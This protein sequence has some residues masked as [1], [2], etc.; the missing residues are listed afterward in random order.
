[1]RFW[2]L[3]RRLSQQARVRALFAAT[4]DLYYEFW[5]PYFHLAIFDDPAQGFDAAFEATH[6][7]YLKAIRGEHAR[8]IIEL[9]CGGGAFAEWL[10]AR[11]T[12]DVLGIDLSDVQLERARMRSRPNLRFRE[13]DIMR[14]GS[15]DEA[16]F[17]AAICMDA[18]TYLPGRKAAVQQVARVLARGGRFL[19]L[20]WCRPERASRLEEELVLAP[21]CRYWGIPPLEKIPEYLSHFLKAGFRL[22]EA[23]DLSDRVQPNWERGY[24]AARQALA[25]ISPAR[26]ADLALRGSRFGLGLEAAKQQ[27]YAAVFAKIAADAGL[28]RY[29]YFLAELP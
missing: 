1:M 20:E 3:T 21:F 8:R 27:Y 7:R 5:G 10:A 26:L 25:S 19:L 4:A 14:L 9:G 16:P 12:A 23:E 24:A 28:L 6:Q 18:A 2:P 17:D 13:H 15:L 11:T 29:A 22:I